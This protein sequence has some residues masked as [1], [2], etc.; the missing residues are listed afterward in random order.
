MC[1]WYWGSHGCDLEDGHSGHHLCGSPEDPC[2]KHSGYMVK[3][4]FVGGDW[5]TKWYPL[6]GFCNGDRIPRLVGP[7]DYPPCP[8]PAYCS[9]AGTEGHRGW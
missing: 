2:S 8:E 3:Y 6:T 7:G 9:S 5:D 1:N 4:H